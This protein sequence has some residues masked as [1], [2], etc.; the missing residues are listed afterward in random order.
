MKPV[1]VDLEFQRKLDISD[2]SITKEKSKV[3]IRKK[4][5]K[6]KNIF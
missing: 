6:T 5:K 3:T 4:T 2:L 1:L